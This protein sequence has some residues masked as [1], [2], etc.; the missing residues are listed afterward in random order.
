M[1]AHG[2]DKLLLDVQTYHDM[3]HE[4]V[5]QKMH[6]I[7]QPRIGGKYGER[8]CG[9]PQCSE[10]PKPRHIA[11]GFSN[12]RQEATILRGGRQTNE[13]QQEERSSLPAPSETNSRIEERS[14]S[15]TATDSSLPRQIAAL[16]RPRVVAAPS[17]LFDNNKPA[18]IFI[19]PHIPRIQNWDRNANSN[20][21]TTSGHCGLHTHDPWPPRKAA[22][23]TR[24]AEGEGHAKY[25]RPSWKKGQVRSEGEATCPARGTKK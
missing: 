24:R 17:K 5:T 3:H 1:G 7:M 16:T 13:Q 14:S 20:R 18:D 12:R 22:Q 25:P 21:K 9:S 8:P 23:E 4:M 19:S 6:Q 2:A 15:L 11:V 10:C